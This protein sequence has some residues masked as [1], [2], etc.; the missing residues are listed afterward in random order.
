[1]CIQRPST[2]P[3]IPMPTYDMLHANPFSISYSIRSIKWGI[4]CERM[5]FQLQVEARL[6]LSGFT[7]QIRDAIVSPIP[8]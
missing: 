4:S 1:M 5:E 6:E 3:D 7:P 2:V 8:L